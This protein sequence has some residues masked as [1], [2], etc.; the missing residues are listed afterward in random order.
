MTENVA[1]LKNFTKFPEKITVPMF[2]LGQLPGYCRLTCYKRD[3][4]TG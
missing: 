1:V 3:S 2:L 4:I